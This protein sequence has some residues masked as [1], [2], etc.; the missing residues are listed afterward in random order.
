MLS[1]CIWAFLQCLPYIEAVNVLCS[2]PRTPSD[3][4]TSALE[5][6]TLPTPGTEDVRFAAKVKHLQSSFPAAPEEEVAAA[7]FRAANNP[8]PAK[9][10]CTPDL[11]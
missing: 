10:V 3:R 5:R 1:L 11:R 8:L 6:Y 9:E 2:G 7:L 4:G